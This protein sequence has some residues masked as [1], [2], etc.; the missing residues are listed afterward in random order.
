MAIFLISADMKYGVRT[1]G[2][3]ALKHP[4]LDELKS[5]RTMGDMRGQGLCFKNMQTTW[6]LLQIG[7]ALQSQAT[8]ARYLRGILS[9]TDM[10]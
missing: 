1:L 5:K 8:R 9:P 10:V 2:R 4:H 3:H 6:F 7:T